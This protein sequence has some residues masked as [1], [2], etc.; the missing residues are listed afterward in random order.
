MNQK[1]LQEMVMIQIEAKMSTLAPI[2]VCIRKEHK[3]ILFHMQNNIQRSLNI[4]R[5]SKKE[6]K[7]SRETET[8]SLLKRKSMSLMKESH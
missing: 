5:T 2:R 4:K 7:V 1:S 3:A 6:I 8:L